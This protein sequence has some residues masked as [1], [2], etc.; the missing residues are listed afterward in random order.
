MC[1]V[2][3]SGASREWFWSRVKREHRSGERIMFWEHLWVGKELLSVRFNRLYV[4]STKKLLYY[5]Y[6]ILV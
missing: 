1:S 2:C 6:G 5:R 4:N 3:H